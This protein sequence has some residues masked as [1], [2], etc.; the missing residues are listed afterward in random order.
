MD[1]DIDAFDEESA[2]VLPRA[3][4][5]AR[6]KEHLPARE[7]R[8]A[9]RDATRHGPTRAVRE[10]R[11]SF[12]CVHCRAFIGP[13]V[14][15]GKHRNHCP[16]CLYSRHVDGN[17]PGDRASDCGAKMAPVARFT[18]PNGEPMIVHRCLGCGFQRNNRLAADDNMLRFED[19]P[20]AMSDEQ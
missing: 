15:G 13:T 1:D 9:T 3:R 4:S 10:G 16:L 12:K 8:D 5:Q 7:G 18:R 17:R 2:H 14:S 19:L 20:E 6:R 11:E